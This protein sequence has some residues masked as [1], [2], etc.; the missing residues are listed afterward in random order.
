LGP[1]F[2]PPEGRFGHRPIQTQPGPVNAL[3][4]VTLFDAGLPE[5]AKDAGLHPL[6]EA[7]VRGGLGTQLGFHQRRPLPP[8]PQHGENGIR[9]AAVRNAGAATTKPMGVHSLGEQRRYHRPQLIGD[10][11]ARCRRVVRGTSQMMPGHSGLEL[12]QYLHDHPACAAP[13]IMKSTAQ[14]Q[15]IPPETHFLPKPF[16]I[17]EVLDLLAQI[18][19]DS[20]P[21]SESAE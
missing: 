17:N 11:E 10:P 1:V 12:V 18:L 4:L 3:D 9:A 20:A 16:D 6:R 15:P 5:L 7:I 21:T 13:N 8:S 2:F 19:P 14:P